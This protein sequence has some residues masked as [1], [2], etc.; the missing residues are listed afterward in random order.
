MSHSWGRAGGAHCMKMCS[1]EYYKT[2][3][4]QVNS[5]RKFYF[6]FLPSGYKPVW[7]A[8]CHDHDILRMTLTLTIF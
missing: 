1:S 3:A 2:N 8:A 4:H 6:N 5:P 7:L